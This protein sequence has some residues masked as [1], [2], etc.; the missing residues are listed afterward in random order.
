MNIRGFK[1]DLSENEVWMTKRVPVQ[2]I[3]DNLN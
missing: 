2:F 3:S 1:F